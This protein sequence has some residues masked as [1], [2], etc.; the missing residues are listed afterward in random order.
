MRRIRRND[1]A[2]AQEGGPTPKREGGAMPGRRPK[3]WA[4]TSRQGGT[5]YVWRFDGQKYRTSFHDDPEEAR[6]DA[7]AQITEQVKGTW[8]EGVTPHT[9][10]PPRAPIT[11]TW[12][13]STSCRS[14]R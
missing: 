13:N 4:E 3:P 2:D 10:T 8:R 6:A 7:T 5:R 9:P 11:G 14:S 12:S 1:R